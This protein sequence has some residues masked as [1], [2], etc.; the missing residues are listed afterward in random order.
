MNNKS[1]YALVLLAATM[2]GCSNND[3]TEESGLTIFE[4][5]YQTK[6]EINLSRGEAEINDNF[7]GFGIKLIN[8]FAKDET[9]KIGN[10]NFALSP[11]SMTLGLSLLAN[12]C[13]DNLT[14][15]IYTA[16]GTKNIDELNSLCQKLMQ[17]LPDKSNKCSLPLANAIW[18]RD[19]LTPSDNY[20]ST[21][22]KYY[23]ADVKP[24][25]FSDKSAAEI[26]NKWC[27]DKTNGLI[28]EITD[29][30]TIS[31]MSVMLVNALYFKAEWQKHFNSAGV[32]T[33]HGL[34]RDSEVEFLSRPASNAQYYKAEDESWHS[35]VIP[36]LGNCEMIVVQPQSNANIDDVMT[37]FTTENLDSITIYKRE[38]IH[39]VAIK[40]PKFNASLKGAFCNSILSRLGINL[41]ESVLQKFND[42]NEYTQDIQ[43]THFAEV[44]VSEKG[45]EAAAA[46]SVGL[47]YGSNPS[48][49]FILDSPFMFIIRNKVSGSIIMAGRYTQP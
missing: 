47:I 43:V 44:K 18:H 32:K 10:P 23:Y 46:T 39:N 1:F 33:F 11:L 5:A 25:D 21:L 37:N 17:F 27:S 15:D 38:H 24:L 36:Y 45:T 29:P 31:Q 49:D 40:M 26:V 4:P 22:N 48:I 9:I 3:I 16:F 19:E 6:A 41:K 42:K 35:V 14:E 7:Q 20:I 13:D 28:S 2:C 8:E 12:T 34:V 30:I